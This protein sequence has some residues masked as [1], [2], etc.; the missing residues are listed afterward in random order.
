M[1]KE[2]KAK[3]YKEVYEILMYIPEED[4][5]KIPRNVIQKI[6][7]DMDK[8]YEYEVKTGKDFDSC[9]MLPETEAILAYI[10]KNY[11]ATDEQNEL[12]KEYRKNQML[13]KELKN[14]NKYNPDNIF[15]NTSKNNEIK[16]EKIIEDNEEKALV[17]VKESFFKKI[18][19]YLK[20]ILKIK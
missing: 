15:E 8:N 16:E 1:K 4:V 19:N 2:I 5:N 6:E 9:V 12:I 3:A 20:N 7:K 18:I 13:I 14:R 17:E 11:W 10:F